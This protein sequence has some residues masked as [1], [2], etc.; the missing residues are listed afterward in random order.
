M[1]VIDSALSLRAATSADADAICAIWNPIIRDTVITFNPVQRSHSDIAAM[2]ADRQQAGHAFL[3]AEA[4]GQLLGFA[5][6]AQFRAGLGY[7]R[8]MEHTINLSPAARG[9]GLG[10]RLLRAIEDHARACA[11]HVMV[12]AITGSN[13]GSI[14]FHAAQGYMQVGLMPQVG[15]KFDQHHDLVLMQKVL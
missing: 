9:R 1:N 6:Y 8:C 3:V 13:D 11:H 14:R 4:G 15:W 5:S 12:A 10:G 2:I 7:A